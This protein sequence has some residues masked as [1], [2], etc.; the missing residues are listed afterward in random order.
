MIEQIKYVY[1]FGQG[2]IFEHYQFFNHMWHRA[3]WGKQHE[4][5]SNKENGIWYLIQKIQ[6]ICLSVNLLLVDFF[7][8]HGIFEHFL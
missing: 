8:I 6:H 4:Y 5:G 2:A 7:I 3:K 1:R